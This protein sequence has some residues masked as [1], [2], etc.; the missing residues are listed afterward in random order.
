VAGTFHVVAQAAGGRP[1]SAEVTVAPA[2]AIS[3]RVSPATANLLLEATL[4]LRA[5]VTGSPDTDVLWSVSEGAAGGS[6][7]SSGLYKAPRA[8]GVYHVVATSHGDA[9]KTAAAAINVADEVSVGISPPSVNVTPG[10]QQR[11]TASV[12]GSDHRVTWSVLEGAAGGAVDG[13]GLY[14]A[15][16]AAGAYHLVATSVA[17]PSRSATAA[18]TVAEN[19]MRDRGG[20]VMPS[21][22]TWALWWG[23]ASVYP[24]DANSTI[25]DFLQGVDGSAYLA[26]DA[27]YLRGKQPTSSFMR[28]LSDTSAA[29]ATWDPAAAGAAA[30]RALLRAGMTPVPQDLVFVYSSATLDSYPYCAWHSSVVCSGVTI[31]YAWVPSALNSRCAYGSLGS[32]C[33]PANSSLAREMAAYTAHEMVEAMTDP[34]ISAWLDAAGKEVADRCETSQTCVQ[35]STGKFYLPGQWSNAAHACAP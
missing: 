5:T 27:Q 34:Y 19:E 24:A 22:R 25:E 4:Q 11:F 6:V 23:D 16:S 15:P 9:S 10:A 31:L 28:H 7:D 30:C 14:T 17:D 32:A 2:P 3:I 8:A 21:T 13:T 33:S 20:P 26:I 12:S 18:V 1:A 29:P 35:L